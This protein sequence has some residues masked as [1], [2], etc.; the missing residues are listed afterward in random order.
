MK[1]LLFIIISLP[2][3]VFGQAFIQMDTLDSFPNELSKKVTGEINSVVTV[4][5][6][7][8]GKKDFLVTMKSE[9]KH[10]YEFLEYWITSDFGIFKKK[11]KFN[12]GIHSIFSIRKSRCRP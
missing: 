4:D 10:N 3:L 7:G 9:D 5:F 6:T 8:D 1:I 2:S 12:D 11:K